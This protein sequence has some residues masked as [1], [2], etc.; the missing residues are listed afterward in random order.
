MNDVAISWPANLWKLE[1][2]SGLHLISGAAPVHPLP[3]VLCFE[4]GITER[5]KNMRFLTGIASAMLFPG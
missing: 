5:W 3:P 2:K 4:Y 1:E